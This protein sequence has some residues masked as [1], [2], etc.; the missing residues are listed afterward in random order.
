MTSSQIVRRELDEAYV[1]LHRLKLKL[2]AGECLRL[3]FTSPG[4]PLSPRAISRD[5]QLLREALETC[6]DL[7]ATWQTIGE[8]RAEIEAARAHEAEEV[9]IPSADDCLSLMSCITCIAQT[10]SLI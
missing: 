4:G 1:A 8:L 6:E 2:W 10:K 7:L 5:R 3:G 9:E